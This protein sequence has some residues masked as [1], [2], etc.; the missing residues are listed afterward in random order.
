MMNVEGWFSAPVFYGIPDNV[1][2][3]KL[4][5]FYNFVKEEDP[6]GRKISNVG[7]WQSRVYERHENEDFLE[8]SKIVE[9]YADYCL[10]EYYAVN[11]EKYGTYMKGG[12]FST[13]V[14]TDHNSIHIH[15]NCFLSGTFYVK[16][17]EKISGNEDYDNHDGCITFHRDFGEKHFMEA[18]EIEKNTSWNITTVS[19]KPKKGQLIIFPSILPHSVMPSLTNEERI[20]L[21]FNLV[22]G[23]RDTRSEQYESY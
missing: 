10:Q 20:S 1:D 14:N 13:N 23:I 17:P 7:G 6:Y 4:E 18:I 9:K 22:V 12:W 15:G 2:M 21:S 3:S 19:Y 8:F 5:R 16:V 11:I